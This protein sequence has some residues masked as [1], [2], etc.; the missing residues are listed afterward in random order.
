MS[1]LQPAM[2]DDL[3]DMINNPD[4][5]GHVEVV[6]LLMLLLDVYEDILEHFCIIEFERTEQVH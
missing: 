2:H 4:G 1:K 3:D 6:E 5:Y